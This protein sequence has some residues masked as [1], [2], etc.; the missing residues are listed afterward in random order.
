ME[1][2]TRM[3]QQIQ[4]SHRLQTVAK[5]IQQ[6]AFLADIGS[7]HAYLP[8]YCVQKA[9]IQKAIAGEVAKG[10]FESAKNTVEQFGLSEQIDVRMADGLDAV[11]GDEVDHI[12]ICGMGGKLIRDIL[13][14][15]KTRIPTAKYL[16]LQPNVAAHHIRKWAVQN[17]WK[18]IQE[19]IL[20]EDQKIYEILVYQRHSAKE[21]LFLDE[22][23]TQFGPFLRREKNQVFLE[24]WTQEWRQLK[25][26]QSNLEQAPKTEANFFRLQEIGHQIKQ[27]EGEVE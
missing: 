6:D 20:K 19:E 15:G 8:V 25:K 16:I 23:D 27:I 21:L 14:R 4:L 18:L 11:T 2:I 13:E 17:H 7:D 26:I 1:C 22:N 12:T 10:P 5:Y 24:K 3:A 9:R